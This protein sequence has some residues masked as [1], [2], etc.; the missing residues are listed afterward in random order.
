MVP[1]RGNDW[2]RREA[3]RGQSVKT[4]NVVDESVEIVVNTNAR[5]FSCV[6]PKLLHNITMLQIQTGIKDRN[7]SN[8]QGELNQLNWKRAVSFYSEPF[9]R[10][11]AVCL[12]PM[13]SW[14]NGLMV[15]MQQRD[16][17]SKLVWSDTSING[18]HQRNWQLVRRARWR[19]KRSRRPGE[20]IQAVKWRGIISS[21]EG[22]ERGRLLRR[23]NT[24]LERHDGNHTWR[25]I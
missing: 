23:F 13:K 5:D 3:S 11:S 16:N 12:M 15:L 20:T 21:V 10:D 6:A 8:W 18:R 19:W 22:L 4:M 1:I 7:N 17:Y 2:R 25:W 24:I 14:T 9:V